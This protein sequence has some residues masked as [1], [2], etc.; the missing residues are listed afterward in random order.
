MAANPPAG[1]RSITGSVV[2]LHGRRAGA[3]AGSPGR[4]ARHGLDYTY[5]NYQQGLCPVQWTNTSPI[6]VRV[7]DGGP[8]DG[9][10][11]VRDLCRQL[12]DLTDL[13]IEPGAPLPTG[14]GLEHLD[15]QTIAVAFM[16]LNELAA[17]SHRHPMVLRDRASGHCKTRID[18]RSGRYSGAFVAVLQAPSDS[19]QKALR[20]LRHQLGH[21]LGLGHAR[22]RHQLMSVSPAPGLIDFA[23]ADVWALHHLY[24]SRPT[25]EATQ[26]LICT[27]N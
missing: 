2:P 9:R 14:A 24:R 11:V 5:A 8:A 26:Q 7:V 17:F 25:D 16:T 19:A 22:T 13:R 3:A 27:L 23:A 6:T 4:A 10:Q 12:H 20:D 21:A 1:Q 15:D 18:R